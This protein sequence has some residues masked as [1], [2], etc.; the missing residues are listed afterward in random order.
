MSAPETDTA[1]AAPTDETPV[2][3]GDRVD[4][5]TPADPDPVDRQAG[6]PEPEAVPAGTPEPAGDPV[7][8]PSP[9]PAEADAA[10]E[11]ES[12][13]QGDAK[14]ADDERPAPIT[15][16]PVA[17]T[18]GPG[19]VRKSDPDLALFADW[20]R[21]E[22]TKVRDAKKAAREARK[23]VEAGEA[24]AKN[25][26]TAAAEVKRLRTSSRATTEDRAAADA[27]YREALAAVVANETGETPDWAPV[28]APEIETQ[29]EPPTTDDFE[30][31]PGA[32]SGGT[33]SPAEVAPAD[34]ETP[35][36]DPAP[37]A[38]DGVAS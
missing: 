29:G 21:S 1:E 6:A 23:E 22:E 17:P 7:L 19:P 38:E 12:T 33:D 30:A 18:A 37:P 16:A 27:A 26:E 9:E 8:E 13:S 28:T 2:A 4:E 3:A 25:K 5:A 15:S 31:A 20:V 24:L 14:P 35:A 32:D 11:A 10:T 36:T 34:D